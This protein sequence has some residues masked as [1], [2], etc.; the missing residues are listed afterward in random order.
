MCSWERYCAFAREP[1]RRA[2]AGDATVSVEGAGYEV[3]PELAGET[4]TLWWGLFDHGV[5]K[6]RHL[7]ACDGGGR[8]CTNRSKTNQAHCPRLKGRQQQPRPHD[9]LESLVQG[10]LVF[11]APQAACEQ[12]PWVK[13]MLREDRDVAV[14][15]ARDELFRG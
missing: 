7:L 15:F 13:P 8:I 11:L 4:V 12:C 1:E 10:H 2:V 9:D 14:D 3:E 6:R 5:A